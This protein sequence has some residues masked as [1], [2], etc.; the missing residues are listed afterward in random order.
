MIYD[1]LCSLE[2]LFIIDTHVSPVRP[3][4]YIAVY[5]WIYFRLPIGDQILGG[6]RG[7]GAMACLTRD[8]L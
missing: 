1:V 8:S 2:I 6:V 4:P 5:H 7:L 3:L